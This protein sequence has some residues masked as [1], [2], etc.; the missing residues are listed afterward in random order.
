MDF[1][2]EQKERF[3]KKQEQIAANAITLHGVTYT[4]A[5]GEKGWEIFRM[6]KD[7]YIQLGDVS[8]QYVEG[9]RAIDAMRAFSKHGYKHGYK[10]KTIV[11]GAKKNTWRIKGIFSPSLDK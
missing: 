4:A 6:T 1:T 7:G 11:S 10:K 8:K 2:T 3:L 5:C 9:N